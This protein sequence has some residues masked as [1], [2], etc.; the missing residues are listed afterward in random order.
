MKSRRCSLLIS[1]SLHFPKAE[2]ELEFRST[3]YIT[4]KQPFYT[5]LNLSIATL[6]I[7]FQSLSALHSLKFS[8]NTF[9]T[10]LLN[11]L[12]LLTTLPSAGGSLGSSAKADLRADYYLF[13]KADR[14]D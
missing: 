1:C 3:L 9:I 5:F 6:T 14:N 8:N 10:A 11:I 4:F 7:V 12:S 13:C 2:Y